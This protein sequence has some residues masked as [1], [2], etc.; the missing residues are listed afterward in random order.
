MN[1]TPLLYLLGILAFAGISRQAIGD[2]SIGSDQNSSPQASASISAGTALG[3][4][5]QYVY[6]VVASYWYPAVDRVYG[7]LPPGK[8]RVRFTITA[9]G[10]LENFEVIEGKNFKKLA[11]ISLAAIKA[12]APFKPF[13]PEIV[14]Q[15]GKKYSDEYTF[16]LDGKTGGISP[17]SAGPNPKPLPPPPSGSPYSDL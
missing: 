16:W 4:Y 13:D 17:A 1:A 2:D 12:P 8:V 5:E 11:E 6:M 7:S 9:Q 15:V 14:K 3:K 10:N